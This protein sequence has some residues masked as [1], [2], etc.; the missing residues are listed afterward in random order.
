M[1]LLPLHSNSLKLRPILSVRCRL[2]HNQLSQHSLQPWQIHLLISELPRLLQ[3][4]LRHPS[5][6]LQL[7]SKIS[8]QELVRLLLLS[9]LFR[10]KLAILS[11]LRLLK[12]RPPRSKLLKLMLSH[13]LQLARP[14]ECPKCPRWQECLKCLEWANRWANLKT[15]SDRL[16]WLSFSK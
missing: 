10:K 2:L 15:L 4:S 16:R 9:P 11:L 5:L 12:H 8:L 3:P 13:R 14:Q 1:E 7:L 6:K